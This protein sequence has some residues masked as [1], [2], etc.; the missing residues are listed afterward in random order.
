[1]GLVISVFKKNTLLNV[2][3]VLWKS[4]VIRSAVPD[5]VSQKSAE[6]RFILSIILN[7]GKSKIIFKSKNF[8][9]AYQRLSV[10]YDEKKK[11]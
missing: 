5:F 9:L 4:S 10:S 1:M 7:F 8:W 3:A 11:L 6:G 2:C